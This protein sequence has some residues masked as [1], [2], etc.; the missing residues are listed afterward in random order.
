ML[1]RLFAAAA[2]AVSAAACSDSTLP[3]GQA[4]Q[5]RATGNATLAISN[6]G[7]EAVFYYVVDPT[8]LAVFFACTPD[9][10]PRIDPGE[11]VQVP[12]AAIAYY[13]PGATQALVDWTQFRAVGDG[14][15][16]QTGSGSV[17]VKL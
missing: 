6:R 10:C 3:A 2:L 12:Y 4:L 14:A 1:K 15:Y 8:E 16:R 5:A 17:L 7:D 9:Q 13:E 11:T